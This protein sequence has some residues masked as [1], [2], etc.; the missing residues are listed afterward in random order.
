MYI[1]HV[2]AIT[3]TLTQLH[4][5]LDLLRYNNYFFSMTRIRWDTHKQ[6]VARSH[7]SCKDLIDK[8]ILHGMYNNAIRSFKYLISC[9]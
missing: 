2:R 3:L 5:V 9:N 7:L 1:S 8:C 6:S 4:G